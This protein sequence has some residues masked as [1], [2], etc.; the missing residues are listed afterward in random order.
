MPPNRSTNN[1]ALGNAAPRNAALA[2]P[3]PA[4]PAARRGAWRLAGIVV[5]GGVVWL[6]VLPWIGRQ[7]TIREMTARNERL[8]IDPCAKFYT[9]LPCMPGIYD[10]AQRH[11]AAEQP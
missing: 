7:P 5:L 10:R 6:A 4:P 3:L 8:G 2:A 11:R 1:D 9:E